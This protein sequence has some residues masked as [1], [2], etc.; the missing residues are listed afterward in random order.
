MANLT[1]LLNALFCLI[2]HC[3]DG[4]AVAASKTRIPGKMFGQ[5]GAVRGTARQSIRVF[6]VHPMPGREERAKGEESSIAKSS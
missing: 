5:V 4:H 3:Q 6:R 2:G 1:S